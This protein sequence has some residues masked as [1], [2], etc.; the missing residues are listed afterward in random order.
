MLL[1]SEEI[2][3]RLE[4]AWNRP[5][6]LD[7][8]AVE[9]AFRNHFRALGLEPFPLRWVP[10][11]VEGHLQALKHAAS[12]TNTNAAYTSA[13]EAASEIMFYLIGLT[14]G[15]KRDMFGRAEDRLALYAAS[16]EVAYHTDGLRYS[17]PRYNLSANLTNVVHT[18]A[19]SASRAS[20]WP[21]VAHSIMKLH[22]YFPPELD[23]KAV[24]VFKVSQYEVWKSFIDAFEAGLWLYWV[25][26]K[27]VVACPRP[28]VHTSDNQLHCETG[29]AVHWPA[30]TSLWSYKGIRVTEEII[31]C[32]ETLTVEQFLGEKNILVRHIMIERFGADRLI[33]DQKAETLD[34]SSW[35]TLYRLDFHDDQPLVMIEVTCPSTGRRYLL[36]VPPALGTAQEAVAWT[37]D[38]SPEAYNPIEQT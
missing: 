31:L 18:A 25:F 5:P 11:A 8:G 28:F 22:K 12:G 27:E 7:K 13:Y 35:G 21:T 20:Y 36:R 38:L 26:Q 9:A 33:R 2:I 15:S 4:A 19:L 17:G 30:G 3:A 34:E 10:D 14:E 23:L 1:T 6:S 32:P 24:E 29:P 37:F 16:D